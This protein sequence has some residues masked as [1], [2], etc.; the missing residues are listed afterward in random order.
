MPDKSKNAQCVGCT[1]WRKFEPSQKMKCC[2]YIV[3]RGVARKRDG[4]VCLS[5]STEKYKPT[6]KVT[7]EAGGRNVTWGYKH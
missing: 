6:R 3:D 5:R 2:H 4:D 7:A 1:Y